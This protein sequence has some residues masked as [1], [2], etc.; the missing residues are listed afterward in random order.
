MVFALV[1]FIVF[2]TTVGQILLKKAALGLTRHRK[3]HVY[4]VYGYF[5]FILAVICS[6]FLLKLIPMK[7]FTIIMSLNYLTVM[8]ASVFFLQERVSV[9]KF[10][11][12]LFVVLGIIVFMLG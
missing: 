9:Y 4:I 12:T 7:F 11:G 5:L 1:I 2:L 6:Y 8:F 10:I 3:R